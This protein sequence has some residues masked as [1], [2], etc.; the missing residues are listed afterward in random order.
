MCGA[1]FILKGTKV[2]LQISYAPLLIIGQNHSPQQLWHPVVKVKEVK[3]DGLRWQCLRN[4]LKVS[5]LTGTGKA[6]E[7]TEGSI[8]G[9]TAIWFSYLC[10]LQERGTASC[11]KDLHVNP[12]PPFQGREGWSQDTVARLWFLAFQPLKQIHH[13]HQRRQPLTSHPSWGRH[14]LVLTQ[15]RVAGWLPQNLRCQ[16]CA[17]AREISS[18]PFTDLKTRL[19]RGGRSGNGGGYRQ[20]TQECWE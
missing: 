4:I 3:N 20:H 10:S 8:L 15:E 14:S 11:I 13:R 2:L 17:L 1:P 12:E 9:I 6:M 7:P 18:V 5:H 19:N 16:P